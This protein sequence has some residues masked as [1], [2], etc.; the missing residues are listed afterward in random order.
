MTAKELFAVIL[1][2]MGL[3]LL[4]IG[5]VGLGFRVI[6]HFLMPPYELSSGE[7][8]LAVSWAFVTVLGL[9]LVLATNVI[10]RMFYGD[11]A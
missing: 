2:S 1:R 5:V 6:D 3:L 10:V 4:V 9:F 7:G 11:S 8:A